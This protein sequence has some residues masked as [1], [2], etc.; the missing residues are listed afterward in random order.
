M[1]VCRDS[2]KTALAG[3]ASASKV[4]VPAAGIGSSQTG[5]DPATAEICGELMTIPGEATREPRGSY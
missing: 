1:V 5:C 3:Q 4:C 2:W